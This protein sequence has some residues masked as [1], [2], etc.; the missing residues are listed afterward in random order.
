MKK[1]NM[2][3]YDYFMLAYVI[4]GI[5]AI[6][7]SYKYGLNRED[8]GIVFLIGSILSIV[9][10]IGIRQKDENI[11][12]QT[13]EKSY[14]FKISLMVWMCLAVFSIFIFLNSRQNYYL[15]LIY[16]LSIS[17]M[18]VI[19][20]MQ[21]MIHQKLS[22]I[23]TCI[24][25]IEIIILSSILSASFL[26]LFPTP[27]G[28]D[29]LIHIG[30]ISHILNTGSI[31]N[32]VDAGRYHEYPIYHILFAET[33]TLSNIDNN[34]ALLILGQVQILF[35]LFVLIICQ[36]LFNIKAGLLSVLLI[37]LATYLLIP[38]YTHFTG[39]FSVIFYMMFIYFLL[40]HS[41]SKTYSISILMLVTITTLNFIHPLIPIIVIFTMLIT[42]ICCNI[43]K[44]NFRLKTSFVF[45][46]IIIMLYQWMRP[47]QNGEGFLETTVGSIKSIFGVERSVTQATLSP[48]YN[49]ASIVLYELGFIILILFGIAGALTF[50]RYNLRQEGKA[51]YLQERGILLSLIT[52]IFIPVPYFLALVY[53]NSLPAR[54]F[55]YIEVLIGIFAGSILMAYYNELLKSKFRYM[56]FVIIFILIFFLITSPIANPN[57]QIYSKELSSRSAL[58]SSEEEGL[59]FVKIDY[60]N[61]TKPDYANDSVKGNVGYIYYFYWFIPTDRSRLIDPRDTKTFSNGLILIRDYDI[62]NGFTIPLWG[63][64]GLLLEVVPPTAQFINTLNAKNKIY[65][66]QSV[67]IYL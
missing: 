37:S 51:I 19:I 38:K 50:I 53:P 12:I 21:I 3:V 34:M 52:L 27:Y 4:A 9:I 7:L 24:I 35:L 22:K 32:Y 49:W 2:N 42:L 39:S 66:S 10:S 43:L 63:T 28:N 23:K 29:S 20:S 64:K 48:F 65:S 11:Q 33:M 14:F 18:A 13:G 6:L 16:F 15:P 61:D 5:G 26:L 36:R 57:S 54:W 59:K 56:I 25:F 40:F 44:L 47:G 8:V 45:F 55:P 1:L 62:N 58:T 46:N 31:E 67:N 30:F 60:I 17:L 41:D